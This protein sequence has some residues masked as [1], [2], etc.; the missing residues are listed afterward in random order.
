LG[1][2]K[3]ISMDVSFNFVIL[4]VLSSMESL[5]AIWDLAV[6]MLKLEGSARTA[7]TDVGGSVGAGVVSVGFS[8]VVEAAGSE[9]EEEAGDVV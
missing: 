8:V 1:P 6:P 3:S 9:E 5:E 4:M 2:E 7:S